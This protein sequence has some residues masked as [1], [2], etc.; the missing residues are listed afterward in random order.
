MGPDHPSHVH[1]GGNS[2]LLQSFLPL[3]S[4]AIFY[5]NPGRVEGRHH[6]THSTDEQTEDAGSISDL[7]NV[8]LLG[9][10]EFSAST[11]ATFTNKASG[12]EREAKGRSS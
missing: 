11:F 2:E 5:N 6:F 12:K 7:A 9:H 4:P 10:L 8:T 1:W 3:P